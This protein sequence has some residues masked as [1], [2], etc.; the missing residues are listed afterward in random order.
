MSRRDATD[1]ADTMTVSNRDLHHEGTPLLV[2]NGQT[3]KQSLRKPFTAA[4]L[5]AAT[6]VVVTTCYYAMIA[7]G[8]EGAQDMKDSTSW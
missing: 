4:L 7:T 1:R 8:M 2:D 6:L 5:L 3:W